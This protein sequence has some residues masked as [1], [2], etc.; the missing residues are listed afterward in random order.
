MG[1]PVGKTQARNPT[2]KCSPRWVAALIGKGDFY[3]KFKNSW[4]WGLHLGLFYIAEKN[5]TK[6]QRQIEGQQLHV[7]REGRGKRPKRQQ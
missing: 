3:L 6:P 5:G 2:E 4:G 7:D 1:P